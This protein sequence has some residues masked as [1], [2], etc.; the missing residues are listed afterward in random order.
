MDV[1]P[2]DVGN[3]KQSVYNKNEPHPPF[4]FF[5]L[6]LSGSKDIFERLTNTYN[7]LRRIAL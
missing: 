5:H 7:V 1:L 4:T 3:E 6:S 2:G